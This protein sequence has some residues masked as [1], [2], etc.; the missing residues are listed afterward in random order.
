MDEEIPV[1]KHVIQQFIR[2]GRDEYWMADFFD[3]NPAFVRVRL[4]CST[5]R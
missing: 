4:E 5:L 3:V 1:I 2:E